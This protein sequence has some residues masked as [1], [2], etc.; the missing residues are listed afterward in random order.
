MLEHF[1]LLTGVLEV[2]LLTLLIFIGVS[3]RTGVGLG[4]MV[5]ARKKARTNSVSRSNRGYR[6]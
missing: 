1:E 5:L 2:D 3:S 6:V 4:S